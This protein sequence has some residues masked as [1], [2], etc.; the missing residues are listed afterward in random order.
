MRTYWCERAWLPTGPARAVA[1]TVDGDRIA[2]VVPDVD[3]TGTVLNGLVMPGFANV[4]SHAFHRALRGRTHHAGGS[5]WTWRKQMYVATER[6]D[7]DSYYRLARAVYAEMVL[8]GF[9]GVGEFHYLHHAPGGV[10]YADPNSMSHA[11]VAAAQD[12]GIRLTL[13][14]TCYLTGGFDDELDPVQ[15]RFSD[16]NAD[17]WAARV[18]SFRPASP[19]ALVGAAVHSV[20]AVP[21][22]Q[23]PTVVT[24]AGQRGAVLHAHVSEQRAEN[25]ACLSVHGRTPIELLADS[26]ALDGDFV[27][28]HATHLTPTDIDRLG[29]ARS[30][31]CF[32]PTTERDLGDG[33]GPA[34][35]VADAGARLSLG[36]D[37][38]AVI[39][40]F[41]EIRGLEMD[42]RL[43]R[44]A[45]GQF[46]TVELVAAA[47][48]H[49]AIG[50]H[51]VGAIEAGGF[52]DLVAVALDSVRTAGSDS[53]G[54]PFCANGSD[55][56]DVI[57][58]GEWVVRDSRHQRIADPARVLAEEVPEL[59]G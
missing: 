12:A 46:T 38:Q 20:R 44:Q 7:P 4:H 37:S 31:V 2:T 15:R 19:R 45:R 5:F 36:S 1:I 54:I 27:A 48:R 58:G 56:R 59:Y 17:R 57:I 16:R 11:L 51:G 55:V 42:E 32:C 52:A 53:A 33:I 24:W 40:P 29:S 43:A 18:A 30:G 47:T 35:G 41:E 39:D 26:G 10:P 8:A 25:D 13:L 3:R 6:L 50:W 14:D 22:E 9:T 28:V 21:A 34:R 23:I 49:A